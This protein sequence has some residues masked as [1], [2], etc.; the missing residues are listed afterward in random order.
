MTVDLTAAP[1]SLDPDGVAWVQDTL[2]NLSL[3]AKVG[4]LFIAHGELDDDSVDLVARLKLGGV[5]LAAGP[6]RTVRNTVDRLK[7]ALSIPPLIAANLESGG[8]G[9]S[10]DGTAVAAPL[11]CVATS[12]VDSARLLG[13]I[14]A[15]EGTA[16]GCNWAFSPV[17]DIHFNWR[18]AVASTRSFGADAET[19][20]AYSRAFLEGAGQGADFG[21]LALTAKHFPGDGVD[22][23][24]Q[25]VVTSVN[26]QT[27]AQWRASFGKVYA[28]LIADGIAT[29]M[30]GHIALPALT[31]EL[32]GED[33][34][35]LPATLAPELLTGLLRGE[36]G[37]NGVTVTDATHMV[38]FTS[39]GERS[40][41]LVDTVNA[42]CD[43]I[44]FLRDPDADIAAIRDAVAEGR[45]SLERLDEAVERV[46]ALKA[47]LELH[48]EPAL[49]A[50]QLER[51]LAVVGAAAHTAIAADLAGRSATLVMD[52]GI[53]PLSPATHPRLRLVP[54]YGYPG[55]PAR[56]P[57][58]VMMREALEEE[59][60]IVSLP[61]AMAR[62]S[63]IAEYI[64]V[65]N[66]GNLA[67]EGEFDAAVVIAQYPGI[68][69]QAVQRLQWE[70]AMGPHVPWWAGRVPTTFVSFGL[71]N[72]LS[73]VPMVGAYVNAYVA[74]QQTV[75]ATVDRL[76]GRAAFTGTANENALCGLTTI[77]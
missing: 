8:D 58:T 48:C 34:P 66:E 53:L 75:T 63:S 6:A 40:A 77:L 22:D 36:L 18:N 1:F 71:P 38:G 2:G 61:A 43:M 37:F 29:I 44:L 10:S 25:H 51:Q 19:V 23:R 31:R 41:L 12:D 49:D 54:N 3:E 39:Q 11:Q 13:E 76:R 30:V 52:K 21:R 57:L 5:R 45:I 62:V 4:Q 26:T 35:I 56:M 67:V 69:G 14:C 17:A 27:P 46:L 73:D 74:S 68:G 55:D 15:R 65:M 59:G 60:F 7:A 28:G 33:A 70:N 20:L 24:D 72:H 16:V 32:A 42:G 47:S 50:A 64:R 9:A